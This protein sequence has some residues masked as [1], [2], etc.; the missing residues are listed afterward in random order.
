MKEVSTIAPAK[1]RREEPTSMAATPAPL[2]WELR[3]PWPLSD[4][5][6]REQGDDR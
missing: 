2:T 5:E 6:G 1:H 3:M 4:V